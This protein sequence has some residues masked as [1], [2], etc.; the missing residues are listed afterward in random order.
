[1][2]DVTVIVA[3][4]VPTISPFMSLIGALCFSMLGLIMPAIIE[5]VTFWDGGLGPHRWRLWKNVV[6]GVFGVIA[7]VFG[8]YT[9][10]VEIV[11]LYTNMPAS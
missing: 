7:M 1:L 6:I 3:V 5:V 4:A 2:L 10:I 9:S 11:K 8:S